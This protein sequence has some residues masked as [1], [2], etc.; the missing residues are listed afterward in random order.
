MFGDKRLEQKEIPPSRSQLHTMTLYI[1]KYKIAQKYLFCGKMTSGKGN[2]KGNN[3]KK[4]VH[5][6]R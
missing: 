3:A 1:A 4:M 5:M 2:I 6:E